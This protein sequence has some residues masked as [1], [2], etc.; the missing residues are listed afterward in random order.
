MNFYSVVSKYKSTFKSAL[1]YLKVPLTGSNQNFFVFNET[2]WSCM[3]HSPRVSPDF[4]A[5]FLNQIRIK[6]EPL[7][8]LNIYSLVQPFIHWRNFLKFPLALILLMPFIAMASLP[9]VDLK[10]SKKI[11]AHFNSL[12]KTISVI[13]S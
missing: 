11:K 5:P 10:R 7:F 12:R 8:C 1:R 3:L 6:V 9:V 4:H 2:C 13:L